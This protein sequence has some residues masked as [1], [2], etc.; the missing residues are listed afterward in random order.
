MR[1]CLVAESLG[2]PQPLD[3]DA[4]RERLAAAATASS[5]GD[6]PTAAGTLAALTALLLD[7]VESLRLRAAA[8]VEPDT[9]GEPLDSNLLLTRFLGVLRRVPELDDGEQ[10][11]EIARQ[12]VV[13]AQIVAAAASPDGET[14]RPPVTSEGNNP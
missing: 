1:T 9:T 8:P 10:R 13:A 2:D 11:A 14:P 3:L 7:E 5:E 12:L 6:W 4:A